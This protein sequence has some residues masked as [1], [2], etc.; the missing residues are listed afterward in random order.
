M[1]IC[2][3]VFLLCVHF[4]ALSAIVASTFGPLSCISCTYFASL[5]SFSRRW[6]RPHWH[7]VI[8]FSRFC[9]HIPTQVFHD[10]SVTPVLSWENVVDD[11]FSRLWILHVSY[12]YESVWYFVRAFV[13]RDILRVE[14]QPCQRT[15]FDT[16]PI[17]LTRPYFCTR[18]LFM[19][20][21]PRGLLLLYSLL[22]FLTSRSFM[23]V[24]HSARFLPVIVKE[25]I[26][27]LNLFSNSCLW[28]Y[29]RYFL[30]P[31]LF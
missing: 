29:I 13:V 18:L 4:V 12:L 17:P 15:G 7:C 16:Q 25:F 2:R 30:S 3:Y 21:R 11:F 6:Y 20:S 26:P 1:Q 8:H 24:T 5:L 14:F 23:A 10:S 27:P 19:L 28:G 31:F 22:S 9:P